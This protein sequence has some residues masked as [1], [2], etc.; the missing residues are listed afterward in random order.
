[1]KYA[2][3][4]S[5]LALSGCSAMT[6]T[7]CGGTNWYDVGERDGLFGG[8]PRIETYAYQCAKQNVQVSEADYMNGWWIGNATYRDRTAGSETN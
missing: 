6:Q 5:L 4:F 3:A 8:P 7:A 1:M 2:I